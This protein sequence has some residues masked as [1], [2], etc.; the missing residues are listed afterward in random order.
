[1]ALRCASRFA[2]VLLLL[3]LLAKADVSPDIPLPGMGSGGSPGSLAGAVPGVTSGLAWE[4]PAM[5]GSC[6]PV[7]LCWGCCKVASLGI[8]ADK[9]ACKGCCAMLMGMFGPSA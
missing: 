8:C 1:M 3:R 7:N 4:C 6:V 5:P 9:P 2:A